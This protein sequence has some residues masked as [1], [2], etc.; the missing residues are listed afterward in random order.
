MVLNN[1]IEEKSNNEPLI[2]QLA[3]DSA[4]NSTL[5][6]GTII[7]PGVTVVVFVHRGGC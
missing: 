2:V 6:L 4:F 1:S 3:R 5:C 7:F